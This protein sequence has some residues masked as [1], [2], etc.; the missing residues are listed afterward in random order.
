M[1]VFVADKKYVKEDFRTQRLAKG[2][3]ENCHF[4]DC[5]FQE[6]FLDNQNFVECRFVNC[7]LTNVNIANTQF[8]DVVFEACKLMGIH[9]ETC[10]PLLLTLQF[11]KCNLSLASFYE[12]DMPN[13]RFENCK[14]HQV[15]FTMTKLMACLF[16]E[17]DMKGALFE[18]ADLGRADFTS[19]VNFNIDPTKN[20]IK[21][22]IFSQS[23]L[24]GLLKKYDIAVE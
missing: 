14:L 20:N 17:C 6:G 2:D 12:M 22:A 13:T 23:G 18:G 10:D 15:D 11:K 4:E 16:P 3:Y 1:R 8:N 7:D 24:I 5:L 9:F 19:A 21:K